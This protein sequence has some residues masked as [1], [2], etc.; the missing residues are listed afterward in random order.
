MSGRPE[1]E[2]RRRAR[3]LTLGWP[4]LS[5]ILACVIVV[6][7]V[8]SILLYPQLNTQYIRDFG[9]RQFEAEYGFRTGEVRVPPNGPSSRLEWGILWVAPAGAFGRLGVRVGDIPFEY[10]SGVRDM[11][12]ALKLAS[13]GEA[14]RFQVYNAADAHLGRKALRNID[15]PPRR[16][17]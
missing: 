8:A 1:R 14:S 10:H 3:L 4:Q 6:F 7:G 2:G 12:A 5:V 11:Y 17:P 9:I 13:K 15:L 16:E